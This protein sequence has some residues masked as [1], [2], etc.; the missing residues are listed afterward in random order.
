MRDELVTI[1]N[2][3]YGPDPV[4]AAEL[5][6]V[7][8]ESEG[9]PCF[10]A[11]KEFIATYWLYSGADRGV[12]LQVRESDVAR[13]VEVLDSQPAGADIRPG[14][15]DAPEADEA[16]IP[17]CPRCRSENVEYERFSKR[18]FYVSL[19]LFSFPLLQKKHAFRCNDCGYTWKC[20]QGREGRSADGEAP[21][22][23][24]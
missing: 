4:S 6:R 7:K 21:N 22:G 1:R 14:L 15:E 10:L 9:I 16:A 20:R 19:L 5:A 18:T 13:A 24:Q 12:K 11:G 17:P 3:A 23:R 2:F 8:L